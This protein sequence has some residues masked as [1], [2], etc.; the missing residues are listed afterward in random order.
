MRVPK[1]GSRETLLKVMKIK[2]RGYRNITRDDSS[3]LLFVY[4]LLWIQ[5][6][7]VIQTAEVQS[8]A[9]LASKQ[10]LTLLHMQRY[11]D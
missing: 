5:V 10:S 1:L 8:M 3:G 2:F 11:R 4:L 9:Y 7:W 6:H